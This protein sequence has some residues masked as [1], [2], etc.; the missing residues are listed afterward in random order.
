MLK[1]Y[2]RRPYDPETYVSLQSRLS[3]SADAAHTS[4]SHFLSDPQKTTPSHRYQ[5]SFSK[6]IGFI[7]KKCKPRHAYT[8]GKDESCNRFMSW[9]IPYNN[10]FETE[11]DLIVGLGNINITPD[12]LG[13]MVIDNILVT[14]INRV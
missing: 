9:L 2:A 13:P 1:A 8:K 11:E 12:S 6:D 7:P 4:G 10:E 3:A 5:S 14:R